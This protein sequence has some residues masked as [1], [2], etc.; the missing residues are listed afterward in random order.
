MRQVYL[1]R[2]LAEDGYSVWA[3]CLGG[4]LPGQVGVEELC[5]KADVLVLPLPASRDGETLNAPLAGEAVKLDEKFA[6]LFEGK[7]VLGGMVAKLAGSAAG[8]GKAHL[9]DYYQREELLV[10]NA[11]LTAEGAIGAAIAGH[12]GSLYGARCLV[13]GF[14]R[15][16]KCLCLTLRGLGAHVDCAARKAQDLAAIQTLGC[17]AVPYGNIGGGYDLIFNTVPHV[18]L[19]APILAKQDPS[20]LLLELASAPGG[21]DREA[22][23]RLGLRVQAE[24]SLPGR[25]SPRK[26]GEIIKNT[27]YNML[28]ERKLV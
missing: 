18:V 8:W 12:P 1:A 24:P 11:M 13:T 3:S 5:R 19:E 28:E 26:A 7:L 23:E 4:S 16:G 25:V 10:G 20:C 21:I 2:G 14:G 15:I 27:L 9:L 6:A 22:A 17:G